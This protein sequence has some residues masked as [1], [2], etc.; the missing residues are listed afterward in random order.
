MNIID[1]KL[2]EL[3]CPVNVFCEIAKGVI[4]RTRLTQGLRQNDLGGDMVEKLVTILDEMSE[5][6][7]SLLIA[8]DWTDVE[9]IRAQL[10]ARRTY[11][12]V[13]KY[14]IEDDVREV[15]GSIE[16]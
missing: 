16:A 9:A 5:L 8:P 10:A 11:K 2:R 6:K 7:N 4:G 15:L 12:T 3:E 1:E 13:V 14:D